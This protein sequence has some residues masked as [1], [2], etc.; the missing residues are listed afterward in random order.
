M[1]FSQFDFPPSLLQGLDEIGFTSPTPIQEKTIPLLLDNHDVIGLAQTGTGKTAA[2]ALPILARIQPGSKHPQALIITPTR[3]LAEQ[4]YTAISDFS[5]HLPVRCVAVYGGISARPQER[6]IQQGVD[7]VVATPGRLL[8]HLQNSVLRLYNLKYLVLDEADR[9]LDMGFIPDI[10]QLITYL[11]RTR[12]TLLFSA[13]MPPEIEKLARSLTHEAQTVEAGVRSATAKSVTQKLYKVHKA[14]KM[15]LLLKLLKEQQ[16]SSV[17]I[18]SQTKIGADHITR[19]LIGAGV[20]TTCIH[21]NYSQTQRQKSLDGFRN[22]EYRVLVAT[23][24][25]A[26]GLDI[27]D[28]SHV[29]NFDT[30]HYAEDYVHRIGR[31]GRASAE[32]EA[33]TFTSREEEKYLNKIERLIGNRIPLAED[34]AATP[35][36]SRPSEKTAKA[37]K[38]AEP[39]QAVAPK[40]KG[41]RTHKGKTD[42]SRQAAAAEAPQAQLRTAKAS[43]KTA[44]S[45]QAKQQDPKQPDQAQRKSQAK[46][47]AKA[48]A[49]PHAKPQ[50]SSLHLAEVSDQPEARPKAQSKAGR[51]RKTAASEAPEASSPA[52]ASK[53]Q[54][55]ETAS[56]SAVRQPQKSQQTAANTQRRHSQAPAASRAVVRQLQHPSDSMQ[57]DDRPFKQVKPPEPPRRGKKIE[58]VQ[59][60]RAYISAFYR[61][62]D[63]VDFLEIDDRQPDDINVE[64]WAYPQKQSWHE[65]QGRRSGGGQGRQRQQP[66]QQSRGRRQQQGAS[67]GQ[68]RQ[69]NAKSRGGGRRSR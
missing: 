39:E 15:P 53:P 21:S 57:P 9:M 31:T 24:I 67:Q 62:D 36:G 43:A 25:A 55:S 32:G 49:K 17:I 51:S 29:V 23:D 20:P 65:P 8:D 69:A 46:P 59:K 61:S 34:E 4:I 33:V 12:Q 52:A 13:T 10:E 16:M 68:G 11:P 3:E 64:A 1:T 60:E 5:R 66:Q 56:L 6:Q 63:E 42:S 19:D 38:T 37:R 40:S 27:P 50:A 58:A 18:F 45:P 14:A 44:S 28:V 22:G 54:R 2:F 47:A 48:H 26:R 35:S 7:I 30:P 41:T